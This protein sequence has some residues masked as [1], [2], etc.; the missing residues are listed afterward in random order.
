MVVG[1]QRPFA[2]L[3]HAAGAVHVARRNVERHRALDVVVERM[4]AMNEHVDRVGIGP[5]RKPGEAAGER[6]GSLRDR[7]AF[8]PEPTGQRR[9]TRAVEH[10]DG[11]ADQ[12]MF[13]RVPRLVVNHDVERLTEANRARELAI[14]AA[15]IEMLAARISPRPARSCRSR[16]SPTRID[17]SCAEYA[18]MAS[19]TSPTNATTP[20]PQQNGPRAEASDGRHVVAD[21]QHRAAV[22][23]DIAHLAEALPLEVE[24]A[25]REHFVD[26]QDFAAQ[27]RRHG[28]RQP[29]VHAAAVMLDRRIE[30]ALDAGERDD[31]I[32]LAANLGAGHPENRAVE[33][34]VLAAG[35]LL[36]ESRAHFEKASDAAVE[37]DFALRTS[38]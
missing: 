33:E 6:A 2:A 21:E 22:G 8:V 16:R 30:K 34:D 20:V 29:H 13:E 38:R 15:I 27:V 3:R 31:G 36:V 5:Q 25:H 7:E 17:S 35:Q 9:D 4:I 19:A 1:N 12:H 11:D 18:A 23:R 37:I 14:R 10:I 26:D 32:E 24:V 28:K